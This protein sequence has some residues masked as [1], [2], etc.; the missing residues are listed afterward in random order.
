MFFRKRLAHKGTELIVRRTLRKVVFALNAAHSG[1]NRRARVYEHPAKTKNEK[2]SSGKG[3]ERAVGSPAYIPQSGCPSKGGGK[4]D[5]KKRQQEPHHPRTESNPEAPDNPKHRRGA[6]DR[7]APGQKQKERQEHQAKR[8][9]EMPETQ[10][11]RVD[12]RKERE[13]CQLPEAAMGRY[14]RPVTQRLKG[15]HIYALW[16]QPAHRKGKNRIAGP[17]PISRVRPDAR[18]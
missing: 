9:E 11:R 18:A 12:G 17:H 6:P 15:K 14:P 5:R 2:P 13:L 16:M 10:V 1:G 7:R 8:T 3:Y 4:R